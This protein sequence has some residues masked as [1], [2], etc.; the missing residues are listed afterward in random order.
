[1][2]NLIAGV[3]TVMILASCGGKKADEVVK[4]VSEKDKLSY[5]L[6]SINAQ[7]IVGQQNSDLKRL[8][9]DKVVEG[10]E[11][12]LADTE[13][14]SECQS[15]LQKL[16]GPNSQDFDTT[17]L[18]EGSLCIGRLTA[19]TFYREMK[20]VDALKKIDLKLTIAGFKHG[21]N[22]VDTL[23]SD[24]EKKEIFDG[25]I[26]DIEKR[27]K[28]KSEEQN[29]KMMASAKAK[30]GA[31]VFE[32]G[33]VIHDLKAGTG[34]SPKATDDVK[35]EYILMSS[36]GDTLQNSY[37]MKMMTGKMEP[38]ALNLGG[39]VAGWSFGL[40]QMKKGG[41]YHLFVPWELA[42]GEQ[43]MYDPQSQ[44]MVVKPFESLQFII[45]VIDVAKQGV[46]VKAQQ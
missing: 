30:A 31:R 45:E 20:E 15:T 2:R 28:T 13:P 43:G 36:S 14:P 42:Y 29:V 37:E 16:F 11:A 38:V 46:F 40:P 41:K 23:I 19:Y 17:Y 21:L 7:A 18:Q 35:I 12:G 10:F 1:M 24:K 4:L 32:N 26:A 44:T 39:V 5:V 25:F 27:I 33:V 6:G 8:N 3:V 22:K 34:V 9:M